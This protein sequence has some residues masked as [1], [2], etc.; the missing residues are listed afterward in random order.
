MRLACWMMNLS[1]FRF[2]DA[3]R[4]SIQVGETKK[5]MMFVDGLWKI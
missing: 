5:V 4:K 2:V 1:Y 3:Y